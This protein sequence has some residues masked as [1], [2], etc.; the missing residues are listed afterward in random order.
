MIK[1]RE[2]DLR[3]F[4]CRNEGEKTQAYFVY[5][6]FLRQYCGEKRPQSA[7]AVFDQRLHRSKR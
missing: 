3:G 1:W 6:K 4:F 2:R 5:V 7:D